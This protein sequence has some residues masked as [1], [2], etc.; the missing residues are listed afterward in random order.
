MV[1]HRLV[2]QWVTSCAVF[3]TLFH[4]IDASNQTSITD[5]ITNTT[6][7]LSGDIT[8]ERSVQAEQLEASGADDSI[9]SAGPS[10][11]TLAHLPTKSNIRKRAADFYNGVVGPQFYIP[12]DITAPR[13]P[14]TLVMGLGRP[15]QRGG[16]FPHVEYVAQW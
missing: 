11:L 2:T 14:H 10:L 8:V 13:Y 7:Q 1:V 4:I 16:L 3:C 5:T 9:I 6:K 12:F 15:L